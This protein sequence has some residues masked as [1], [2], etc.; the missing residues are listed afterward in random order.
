[1]SNLLG[2]LIIALIGFIC[3]CILYSPIYFILR[4]RVGFLRQ[5]TSLLLGFSVLLILYVTIFIGGINFNSN[6][7]LINIVPFKFMMETYEMGYRAMISQVI[8]NMIMFVPIGLLLPI[9]FK[10]CR[11]FKFTAL[12]VF[13]F[14]FSIEFIQ[15]FIGRSCDVD[16]IIMNFLGG[17]VG[18]GIYIVFRRFIEVKI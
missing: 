3:I 4:K 12:Y 13:L 1:M 15:Y 2:Y 10:K 11:E 9:V 18:Y 17:V 6:Y 7:H 16:D 14:T 8:S 5:L